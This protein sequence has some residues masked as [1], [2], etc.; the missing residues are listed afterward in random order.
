S[1]NNIHLHGRSADSGALGC[2][3]G[4]GQLRSASG[5]P[6]EQAH[7]NP[8]ENC[9]EVIIDNQHHGDLL[10]LHSHRRFSIAETGQLGCARGGFAE[11]AGRDDEKKDHANVIVTQLREPSA[12]QVA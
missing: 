1:E 12:A 11:E 4:N 3:S 6:Y 7:L 9:R 5:P 8:I 2:V 10:P